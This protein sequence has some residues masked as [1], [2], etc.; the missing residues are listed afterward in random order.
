M[1]D[2]NIIVYLK[3]GKTLDL[4]RVQTDLPNQLNQFGMVEN[5]ETLVLQALFYKM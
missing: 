2:I 3:D 1:A 5:K 4:T